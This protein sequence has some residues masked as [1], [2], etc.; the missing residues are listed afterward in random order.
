[1]RVTVSG[2]S[3]TIGLAC[4][5]M[6]IRA[7]HR[8]RA[9]VRDPPA[10]RAR[11][12]DERVE[13]VEGDVLDRAAVGLALEN[14][15]ALIYCVDFAPQS[16]QLHWDAMH[17]ALE[18]L[19]QRGRLVMPGNDSVYSR[20]GAGRVR[21]NAPKAIRPRTAALRAEL[22]KAILAERGTVVHLPEVYGPRVWKGRL[23]R[24]FRRALAG[25]RV[26]FPG[27]LD[28]ELEFLFVEDAARALIAPLGR[29]R[30]RGVEYTAPGFATTTPGRFISL[31]F[32]AA[33]RRERIESIPVAWLK[34]AAL[35]RRDRRASRDLLY[36]RERPILF[37]GTRIRQ[38][39]GWMP[40]VDYA[41]G[42]RRTC[43]WLRAERAA[44]P[45]PAP[46]SSPRSDPPD[47]PRLS[48]DGPEQ[49]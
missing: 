19:G 37:D 20:V 38:E 12:P 41:D 47:A 23:A 29:V 45:S 34:V 9:L 14:T 16:F 3:G 4:V 35:L 48:T 43:K 40:E 15:D 10:F 7:G 17:I 39:L 6:A 33:G 31:I 2:A 42:V 44:K 30:S 13:I 5:G 32:K 8:V 27:D 1:M 46:G 22:E 36:L 28:R 18:S 49:A 24:A 25:A 26:Y 11:C 21:P